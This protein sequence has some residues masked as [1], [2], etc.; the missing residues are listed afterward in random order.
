MLYL[1]FAFCLAYFITPLIVK[2]ANK[3][4][5]VDDP[6]KRYHPAHTHTGIVPRAGG[7]GI[8]IAILIPSLF[9]LELTKP[10][11]GILLGGALVVLVGIWDDYRDLS[12]YFRIGMNIL[13]AAIVVGLGGGIPYISNP[14]GEPIHLDTI[15]VSFEFFGPHSILILSSIAGMVWIVWMMNAIGWSA[16]VDGQLPGFVVIACI[17]IAL[18]ANRFAAYDISQVGVTNLALIT[19]GAFLGFLPWN[20]YPQKIMPGYGGKSLAGFMLACLA[21]ISFVKVG[22]AI[23]VLGV[24]FVDAC[25]T[26][27]RRLASRKSP[28]RADRGHLH[29][30]LLDLGWGRRRIAFFYWGITAILGMI[31]LSLDS[32]GKLVAIVIVGSVIVG[33]LLLL[34][35]LDFFRV[36]R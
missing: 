21:I 20:Y 1:I 4:G 27:I 32:T 23:L 25:Y 14:F 18:L 17:V 22:T 28:F 8:F 7:I 9:F 3:S 10:L 2:F 31:A 5:L 30:H 16:G 13:A 33:G 11:I 19:A 26:V 35:L 24:P 15:R 29:H 36:L 12:P 34:Q 6:Q